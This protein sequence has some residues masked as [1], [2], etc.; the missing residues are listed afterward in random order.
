VSALYSTATSKSKSV[1]KTQLPD[2][3][4]LSAEVNTLQKN[5]DNVSLKTFRL[6][7]DSVLFMRTSMNSDYN[8]LT[9]AKCGSN[10][11]SMEGFPEG[12]VVISIHDRVP[13]GPSYVIRSSQH[14]LLNT[15]TTKDESGGVIC[16]EGKA[17]TCHGEGE[18]YADKLIEHLESVSRQ[19]RSTISKAPTNMKE[20]KIS[21]L[22]IR[23]N[24]PYWLI[25]SGNC[26]HFILFNQIRLVHP[27]DRGQ[28]YPMTIQISPVLMDLCRACNKIPATWSIVG[29]IRLGES[30]CVLCGPCWRQMGE[31]D[32]GTV[33]VIPLS[34]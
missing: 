1:R 5:V 2:P 29:D 8:V 22:S 6:N 33:L 11:D 18:D 9:D 13:W 14:A 25:H 15:L 26:E 27:S 3:E 21:S 16:I 20:T 7:A 10:S 32:D 23:I 28:N 34:T 30:P 19:P 17:F 12:V 24:E 31:S 4:T